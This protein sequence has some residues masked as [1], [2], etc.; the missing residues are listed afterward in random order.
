MH[1]LRLL[2]FSIFCIFS[3][4]IFAQTENNATILLSLVD[5]T[6]TPIL[7]SEVYL[8]SSKDSSVIAI[9]SPDENGLVELTTVQDS[10]LLL[11][12]TEGFENKIL[13]ITLS[14]NRQDLGKIMLKPYVELTNLGEVVVVLEKN[15]MELKIDKRI[16][17]VSADINNQGGTASDVLENIPSV[18]VDAEGNVSLR[19]NSNVRILIDGKLSGFASTADALKML[20]ADAIDRIE[21]ITNASSRYDAEGDAGIINIILKKDQNKGFNAII[22]AR[23]G[24]YHDHGLGVRLNYKKNKLNLYTDFNFNY[25]FFPGN[26]TTYQS[27]SN[28]DTQMTYFQTYKHDREKLRFNFRIGADY[29]WNPKHNTSIDFSMR[30]GKGNNFIFRQYDNYADNILFN[31]DIRLE[32][33]TE[34]EKL[35][36]TNINHVYNF[37]EKGSWKNVVSYYFDRD[38]ENSI[39]D[40]KSSQTGNEKSETSKAYIDNKVL[41]FQSDLIYPFS[42]NG[43]VESGIRLQNRIFDNEYGYKMQVSPTEWETP[44]RFNDDVLYDETIFA[45]YLMGSEMFGNLG[46]QGGL[47]A[48]HTNVLTWLKSTPDKNKMTYWNFFPSAAISYKINDY[49]NIQLSLSRRIR[50]P[51]QWDLLPFM[52]FGDN[53]EI[54][55][56]N[57]NLNPE[58]TYST[59]LTWMRY[60][61]R[62]SILASIYY[63][64]TKDKIERIAEYGSDGIIYRL[65]L[66]IAGSEALGSELIFTYQI[67]KWM[68]FNTNFNLYHFNIFGEYNGQNFDRSTFTWTN[69]SSVNFMLPYETKLQLTGQYEAP[70]IN[71]QGKVLSVT[72]FDLALSK[73]VMNQKATI[74]FNVR[75]VLNTRI[76]R[77]ITQTEEIYSESDFQWRPRSFML[78]FTYRFNQTKKDERKESFFDTQLDD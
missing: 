32:D 35:I 33:Q 72:W 4:P 7:F 71:P 76:H 48:E 49:N 14:S 56:G 53:R 39:Y 22:N 34:D 78:T 8:L 43:K 70:R 11:I 69:R 41:Q 57:P 62:G 55:V 52:K 37:N 16:Y 28:A 38:Y 68:R 50:R 44:T 31:T 47:R 6:N 20:Q 75:D 54:R 64:N 40:E 2:F 19:G 17:N 30:N 27:L 60:L 66:N 21:V 12:E 51:G 46:V 67:T 24:Y 5:T 65:P 3:L 63:K 58:L 23:T 15:P 1:R 77:S 61:D 36:E 18:T 9:S 26:S 45:A 29:Q 25:S 13:P 10:Y 73:D 59:E 42:E 74:G